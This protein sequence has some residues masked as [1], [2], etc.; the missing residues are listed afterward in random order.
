MGLDPSLGLQFE[1]EV[2]DKFPV[3]EEREEDGL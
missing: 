3:I 2:W 1:A